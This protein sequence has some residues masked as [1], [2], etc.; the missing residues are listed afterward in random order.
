[1]NKKIIKTT[2]YQ[3]EDGRLIISVDG[4]LG[5]ISG[6]EFDSGKAKNDDFGVWTQLV[7]IQDQVQEIMDMVH[8]EGQQEAD[9]KK[10]RDHIF[11]EAK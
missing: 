10:W 6:F 9:A 4:N 7:G 5:K 3:T 1:M 11:K 2:T 8:N